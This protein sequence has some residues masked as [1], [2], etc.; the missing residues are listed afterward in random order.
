MSENNTATARTFKSV[1]GKPLTGN[2]GQGE[3]S[4]ANAGALKARLAESGADSIIAAEGILESKKT[5]ET[6]FGPKRQYA[7]RTEA[8]DLVLLDEAGNLKSQ[9][10]KVE[11][12]QYVQI[13]YTGMDTISAGKWKGQAAHK[14]IVGVAE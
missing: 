11:D 9:M 7:V 6:K 4:F 12:G 8:G 1:N 2:E 10:E 13:T 14:Y 3:L 5:V